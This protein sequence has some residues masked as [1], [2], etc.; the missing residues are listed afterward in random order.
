MEHVATLLLTVLGLW[1]V[2]AVLLAVVLGKF[3]AGAGRL[4]ENTSPSTTDSMLL[5]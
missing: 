4:A 5:R 2:L 1:S 3:L